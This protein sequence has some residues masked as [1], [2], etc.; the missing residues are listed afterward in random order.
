MCLDFQ[1]R[2]FLDVFLLF[3]TIKCVYWVSI[4]FRTGFSWIQR[5][6]AEIPGQVKQANLRERTRLT[7][8]IRRHDSAIATSFCL[9]VLFR[10]LL[11]F[12]QLRNSHLFANFPIGNDGRPFSKTKSHASAEQNKVPQL[13]SYMGAGA[14]GEQGALNEGGQGQ[15]QHQPPPPQ[16]PPQQQ[17]PPSNNGGD[18]A[19]G[20]Q[21][22]P[23]QQQQRPPVQA[24]PPNQTPSASK[25]PPVPNGRQDQP[26]PSAQGG[27][28]GDDEDADD[29]AE[30]AAEK[31]RLALKLKDKRERDSRENSAAPDSTVSQK[32]PPITSTPSNNAPPTSADGSGSP[33]D[34]APPVGP[35]GKK[36]KKLLNGTNIE[37]RYPSGSTY[38]GGFK[39]GK[40][41]GYG[42]YHYHP[43]ND[44]YEGEWFADMKHGQGVYRYEGGDSYSGEWRAGKKHGKGS[45]NFIT[46]DEYV[47]SW[48]EDKIHGYGV[49]TIARNGNRYEGSWEESYRHGQGKLTSGTGDVYDGKWAKGKE[50]GLGVL[51]YA[52]G[53]LYAGDW[54]AGQMDGK[55]I[56]RERSQKHT[57][58]H[59]AGYLIAKVPID[60]DQAVD[61]DWNPANRL[62]LSVTGGG[63]AGGVGGAAGG[64]GGGGGP[65]PA[66]EAMIGKL[67]VERDMWEKRYLDLVNKT[68]DSNA[69]NADDAQI[70][71]MRDAKQL[72]TVAKK[73]RSQRDGEKL[74]A[75][76]L[77][78]RERVLKS[79]LQENNFVT[80]GLRKELATK[81]THGG[82][83]MEA[84]KL[85]RRVAEL[86]REIAA[87][88]GGN[89]AGGPT[90]DPMEL[91]VRLE[92]AEG[93]LKNLRAT[94]DEVY[95]L[96]EQNLDSMRSIQG[97]EMRNEELIKE[98][99]LQRAK[100]SN[101]QQQIADN[102]TGRTKELEDEMAG[103][104]GELQDAQKRLAAADERQ[105]KQRKMVEHLEERARRADALE[106]EVMRLTKL[107]TGDM[108]LNKNLDKKMDQLDSLRRQNADLQRQV[109]ELQHDI[110][111]Q[112]QSG[113][114][115]SK[116]NR[117]GDDDGEG[118]GGASDGLAEQ[119]QADLKK[120]KKKHKRAAADRDALAQD[121]FEEQVKH[122]RVERTLQNLHGR[123]NVVAKVRPHPN[124]KA[125][126]HNAAVMVNQDDPSQMIVMD[127][128]NPVA[129][130]FDTCLGPDHSYADLFEEMKNPIAEVPDGYHTA[131][132]F[133]GPMGSGK[134][135]ALQGLVPLITEEL[136][137]QLAH[138][139]NNST[140]V[141]VQVG[142]VELSS[143]GMFDCTSGVEILSVLQDPQSCVTPIG[144]SFVPCTNAVDAASKIKAI[145]G[146]RKKVN[147]RS[148]LWIQVRTEVIHK[149]HQTKFRGK[150][151][152]VDLCGPG[153]LSEQEADIESAKFAN[154]A[155]QALGGVVEALQSNSPTV[156]YTEHHTTALLSDVLGG[157]AFSTIIMCLSPSEDQLHD[158]VQ[159]LQLANKATNVF[160]RPLVQSF[161]NADEIRLREIV[162]NAASD[163]QAQVTMSE[164]STLR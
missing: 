72:Q 144:V 38:L 148:H 160:N 70:D 30:W 24:P 8:V 15:Q 23:Q 32:K 98:M 96:R 13:V 10:V 119:L 123:I 83:S 93:E 86:E 137:N 112:P 164:V 92:L 117:G 143:D 61:P 6:G 69:D 138:R 104:R 106:A 77:E 11:T 46:G 141:N 75:D 124:A 64:G 102:N 149:V 41:H 45:Y 47:G 139:H 126:A 114:K 140:V 62:Y 60:A 135:T 51:T 85:Q 49:F 50:E 146:K 163:D 110:T 68:A 2:L 73:L 78:T 1:L 116:K 43:S 109:E 17:R 159:T 3:S 131:Y 58:E 42:K 74:R 55:G 9:E 84:D 89:T 95:K 44:E 33:T 133:L 154:R 155:F 150:L 142:C 65:D 53:N 90:D 130:Q 115:K 118:A 48:K 105:Q 153:S 120:E 54:K 156:P 63:G 81:S 71:N 94:R 88:K 67:K 122:A 18:N 16:Q 147:G 36:K 57:V 97:L 100:A 25:R 113:K 136:Y 7:R 37:Y 59:I 12:V 39:D 31:E 29:A 22:P 19:G 151:T 28:G 125:D 162:S 82:D 103:V 101:L 66:Q 127:E 14:S 40:L 20:Q 134:S 132:T 157:N 158:S 87:R 108:E 5:K 79:E 26:P 27:R 4:F 161:V 99:N 129:F 128:G 52:N 34:G 80:E 21:P 76:E 35:D 145:I 111:N 152:L 121:L 91:K 107:K 56:M